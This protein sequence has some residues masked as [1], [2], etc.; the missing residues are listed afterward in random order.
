MRFGAS[1]RA[2]FWSAATHSVTR[3]VAAQ[4]RSQSNWPADQAVT[5]P[6]HFGDLTPWPHLI[7][8]TKSASAS[9]L[10]RRKKKRSCAPNPHRSVPM[11]TPS[12][13]K[14]TIP[15]RKPRTATTASRADSFYPSQIFIPRSAQQRAQR[16]PD[17]IEH[18]RLRLCQRVNS[19]GL[20]PRRSVLPVSNT[21]EQKRHQCRFIFLCH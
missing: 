9:W 21:L 19:I 4:V 11:L 16:W 20:K 18:L 5:V 15:R 6:D 2:G 17:V 7:T 8:D 12:P 1:A 10:K 13:A 3:Q 14:T